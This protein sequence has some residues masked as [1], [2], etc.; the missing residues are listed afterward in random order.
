VI[1][2]T[3]LDFD[4][5]VMLILTVTGI[6]GG[7]NFLNLKTLAG[8]TFPVHGYYPV[9]LFWTGYKGLNLPPEGHATYRLL[10]KTD[11]K[12]RHYSLKTPEIFTEFRLWVNGELLDRR[13]TLTGQEVLF[14]KPSLYNFIQIEIQLS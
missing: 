14:M 7:K 6:S 12:P 10:I 11:G 1:D 4:K 5:D 13:G 3:R 8:L 2:L 9:P